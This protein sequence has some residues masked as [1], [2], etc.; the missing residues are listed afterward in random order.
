MDDICQI[1]NQIADKTQSRFLK[2]QEKSYSLFMQGRQKK[3]TWDKSFTNIPTYSE[4][5]YRM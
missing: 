4:Y 1:Y 2:N 3:E 5:K